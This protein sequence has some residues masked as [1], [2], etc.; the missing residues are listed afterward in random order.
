MNAIEKIK[1]IGRVHLMLEKIKGIGRVHLMFF[2]SFLFWHQF[3]LLCDRLID[4]LYCIK[5]TPKCMVVSSC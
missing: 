1:G 2:F 5:N 4:Y 3:A